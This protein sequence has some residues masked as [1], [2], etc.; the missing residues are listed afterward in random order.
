MTA[1]F[2]KT[3]YSVST[4]R[5]NPKDI[6]IKLLSINNPDGSPRWIWNADGNK[7]LFLKFY[8][9]GSKRALLFA[10]LIR[11]LFIIKLQKIV[12]HKKTW[13]VSKENEP[14][15]DLK[16]DWA[17]FTGTVGPNNKAILYANNS[18]Y[19]IATTENS[20]NL[21]R[22]EHDILEKISATA[23]AFITPNSVQ[24]SKDIIQLSDISE[25]GKRTKSITTCHLNALLEMSVI[26]KQ[27]ISIGEWELFNN[28]KK[29]FQ[30]IQDIRIP[31]NMLRKIKKLLQNIDADE[32]V[33]LSLSQ[34]D[35]T[36]WNMYERNGKIAIYDW[37]LAGYDKPKAFDYFHFIIQQGVLVDHK[38]WKAIYDDIL[39]SSKN[40]FGR[41]IFNNNAEELNKYLKWYLLVTCMQ[42]LKIYAEQ[43]QWHIQ[44]EW[45]LQVW[46]EA[47][48]MF[49]EQEHAPRELLIMDF[50]D[51]IQNQQYAALKFHNDFPEKLSVNSDIDLVI[52]KS[53]NKSIL[54]LLKNHA[55]A[56]KIT[57]NK[58]SFMNSI[59]V[60]LQDGS[61]L[62]ID[63]IWQLK[64]KNLEI[65]NTQ[66]IIADSY[67]GRYGVRLASEINTA[68]FIVLF[69]ILNGAKIPSK[70]QAY[71]QAIEISK[72]PLDLIA[73]HHYRNSKKEK[74]SLLNFIKENKKNRSLSLIKNTLNYILDTMRSLK[75][76]KG[77]I[78]TFSGVDG[79]GKS[80]VIE[81]VALRI[82]K[83]LRKPV[84][85]LRHRPSV[86]PILSV[87]S[88]G[89]EQAHKEVIESLPRQGKNNSL[90][91][92]IFRFSYYY[93]DYSVG[94]FV[95]YFKYIRRGYVVIYDRYYF[96]FINDSRR[97]NILLPKSI[98]T[99]G[100]RLLLKPKFNFFLFADAAVILS[101]KKELSKAT[102]EQLTIDYHTL[103]HKL[104]SKSNV[105]VYETINNIELEVTLDRVVKTIILSR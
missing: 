85:V 45:L 103:F 66:D 30:G 82:E 53:N 42:Y 40:E 27:N 84:V 41:S 14:V 28:L 5:N 79:A 68:R 44:I 36:Q 63:L 71:Q 4:I 54:K 60:F 21:I 97:S 74:S 23:C 87:W 9:I 95:I 8:N 100:Y 11:L 61:I 80:T 22:Q 38:S 83:Q 2:N 51:A 29:D 3:G 47:L 15:F 64:I 98:T 104:Q 69:Y 56:A 94:Q 93:L 57:V 46:N 73:L 12:F 99:F 25:N 26:E 91:S 49:A 67:W 102:I 76:S 88:K 90:L 31:K 1:I 92:S 7:P 10:A 16:E 19:K 50:F 48:N 89:K 59:L 52:D 13:F 34:G 39:N 70:Y 78:V 6:V 81:N 17:L 77:F 35:F 101:R 32:I 72:R 33:E 58:K 96:D 18:F 105:A 43:P 20:E 55:L 37:E 75:N 24:I 65:L 86:L 62:S